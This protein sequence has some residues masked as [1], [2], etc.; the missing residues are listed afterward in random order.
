MV[1]LTQSFCVEADEQRLRV[2]KRKVLR[3]IFGPK[4]N[5]NGEYM[6]RNN[7]ELLALNKGIDIVQT[8][9]AERLGW[10]GHVVRIDQNRPQ[11]ALIE[12]HINQTRRQGRPTT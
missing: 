8:A 12:Y 11:K 4:R 7:D 10:L 5:E 6:Q 2:L 1:L 9:K 3:K